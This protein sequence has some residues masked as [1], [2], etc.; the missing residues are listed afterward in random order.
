MGSYD[1]SGEAVLTLRGNRFRYDASWDHADSDT[2]REWLLRFLDVLPELPFRGW[3]G[4]DGSWSFDH[5]R[6]VNSA[7]YVRARVPTLSPEG[8]RFDRELAVHD[9]RR[10]LNT[11]LFSIA[12]HLVEPWGQDLEDWSGESLRAGE[13]LRGVRQ[14]ARGDR[15]YTSIQREDAQPCL[16]G[17]PPTCLR[18]TTD[19]DTAFGQRG[20]SLFD[21]DVGGPSQRSAE[22]VHIRHTLWVDADTMLP[23]AREVLHEQITAYETA[24]G[25][26][27]RADRVV[28]SM[29]WDWEDGP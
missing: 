29:T 17:R 22:R 15:V 5:Q 10:N 16:D 8:A 26:E 4:M 19:Y 1:L 7:G 18:L 28:V 14:S 6:L 20:V 2:T 12:R 24:D 9:H 11:H 25:V 3:L 21:L 27:E 23:W 13:S